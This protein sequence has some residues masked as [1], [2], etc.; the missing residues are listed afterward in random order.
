RG[1]R[2]PEDIAVAGYDSTEEG[3]NGPM[4]ITSALAPARE[5]GI[6]SFNYLMKSPEERREFEF[7]AKPSL[8]TGQTCGCIK[9]TMPEPSGRRTEWGTVIS[10]EAYD[11]IYNVMRDEFSQSLALQDF[12]DTVY[13]HA[14]QIKDA[15]TFSLIL[16]E[17]WGKIEEDYDIRVLNDKYPDRMIYAVKYNDDNKNGIS[18]TSVKFDTSELLPEIVNFHN[19]ARGYFITPV[20]SD[21]QCFGYAVVSYEKPRCYDNTYRLW[22]ED[23]AA[24]FESLRKNNFIINIQKKLDSIINNK[25]SLMDAQYEMLNREDKE[26][27]ELVDKILNENLLTYHFQPIVLTS[28]GEIYSYEALMRSNTDIVISPL[29]IIKYAGMQGRLSDV[30]YNTFINVLKL[31]EGY[32]NVFNKAKVFVNS[33][34]GIKVSEAQF[35]EIE[36]KMR[37]LSKSIVVELTEESEL[38]DENLMKL[39]DY[40]MSIGVEIALDDYGTGYSNVGN[41]LRYMPN[42]V[43]IDRSLLSGIQNAPQKQHFVKEIITYCHDNKIMAL[44]EGVETSEELRMVIHLGADLIQGYYTAKPTSGIISQINPDVRKEIVN[45][46]NEKLQGALS[47]VYITGK[48]NMI[49]L[50]SLVNENYTEILVGDKNVVY[51]DIVISGAP[52]LQTNIHMKCLQGY[53]GRI[54]LE[55]VTF[56]NILQ[57]PCIELDEKCDVTLVLKGENVL[58]NTGIIVPVSSRL[59]LEG[60]GDMIINLENENLYSIGN[61]NGQRSG[62]I[63]YYQKGRVSV[64]K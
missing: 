22:I 2:I 55:N 17:A 46:Y 20:F 33:I 38:D 58:N 8:L 30:E 25:F 29:K 6:Y 32:P 54:T 3:Q 45:Y 26:E 16:C 57:R 10:Q 15:K 21:N 60:E 41:L 42:Y 63:I 24:G 43:K 48:T 19:K 36:E 11:S 5:C 28:N 44:A 51:K 34:P 37:K 39:K 56:S 27:Y 40:F 64:N 13:S 9:C 50:R 31:V 14:Y 49:S 7:T 35:K 4:S 12:V 53:S 1:Y 52:N 59:T 18:G 47:K 62:E 23:V 61:K